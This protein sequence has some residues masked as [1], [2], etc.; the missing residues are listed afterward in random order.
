MSHRV[1]VEKKVLIL[2]GTPDAGWVADELAR[3]GYQIAWV[4]AEGLPATKLAS[5]QVST[6]ENYTL[7]RLDGHVGSFRARFQGNGGPLDI[8]AS[9]LVV[10]TGN[11]RYSPPEYGIG[12]SA[13]VL[14]VPQVQ[15]QLDAPRTTG[16]ALSYRNQRMALL[17]D[18]GGETPKE[19]ATE[20]L[21]LAIRIRE[22]WHAEV[23][24]FYRNLQVDTYNL[25]RLTRQMRERGI[26]FNRYDTLKVDVQEE[27]VD[28]SYV[29]GAIRTDLLILPDMVRPRSDTRDLAA[30]LNVNVGEDGYFQDVNIRQY[31]PG[32][33][34]RQGI[35]FAGRCHMDASLIEAQADAVQA[36]ANVDALLG[37][38]FLTPEEIIAHVDSTKC[39]RCLTCVR[40]CPHAAVEIAEYE[41]VVAARVADLAC[42]GCGACVANC[43]VRAIELVGQAMPAWMQTP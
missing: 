21:E 6:Y 34:N 24:V 16:A 9:A 1:D 39:V 29:E 26:V 33:S 11:E 23:N 4:S 12:P 15:R 2:G 42:R 32:L 31:R 19:T 43:P 3:L 13:H 36:A 35:F 14:T 37:Q 18:W 17:L 30:L 41:D 27:G 7:S 28:L 22:Q 38:G 25:E 40:T 20:A 10:A 5:P 8:A